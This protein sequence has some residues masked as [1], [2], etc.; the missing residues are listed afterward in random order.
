MYISLVYYCIFMGFFVY[1]PF[2]IHVYI[3]FFD[4]QINTTAIPNM[5]SE[6]HELL[7]LFRRLAA[8]PSSGAVGSVTRPSVLIGSTTVFQSFTLGPSFAPPPCIYP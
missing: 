8:S 1:F 2:Y 6:S 7:M 5:V 3:R 4:P